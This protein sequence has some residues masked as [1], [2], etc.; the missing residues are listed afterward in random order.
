MNILFMGTPEFAVPSLEILIQQ[1]HT[2]VAV[3]T[4]PD[5]PAGRGLKLQESPVKQFAVSKNILLLQPKNLRHP[6]FILALQQLHIDLSVVVAF[7]ML[8]EV[9]W[10]IP[11]FG[12]INLHASLLPQYRGAAPINWA[13]INGEKSTGLTTFFIEKEIDTGKII[14]TE[15]I[16]I[17]FDWNAGQLHDK[18]KIEGAALVLK[19]VN[20][21]EKK[22]YSETAQFFTNKL[23][24]APKLTNENCAVNWNQ[25]ALNVYNFIRGLSPFPTAWTFLGTKKFKIFKAHLSSIPSSLPPGSISTDG[26]TFLNVHTKDVLIELTEIQIEGKKKMKVLDFLRGY[27]FT[28]SKF[29]ST[30]L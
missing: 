18:L 27:V 16:A 30:A 26:K 20:A 22:Q 24:I 3:V 13:I 8:P 17:P 15:N 1:G 23:K 7:R 25:P 5:K 9:V 2:I 6:D 11:K 29:V 10:Q 14:F 21:I 19:T 28:N 12:T 4:A